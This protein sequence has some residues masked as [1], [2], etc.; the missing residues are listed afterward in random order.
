M[1]TSKSKAQQII[2]TLQ[3]GFSIGG[4]GIVK[5]KA[6]QVGRE[7]A[8]CSKHPNCKDCKRFGVKL[9]NAE[10]LKQHNNWNKHEEFVDGLIEMSFGSQHEEI[11]TPGVII[12]WHNIHIPGAL[13]LMDNVRARNWAIY[14]IRFDEGF[15]DQD[16]EEFDKLNNQEKVNYID[17]VLK[18]NKRKLNV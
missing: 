3:E 18:H 9:I 1:A 6:K 15:T 11:H 8:G 4:V 13:F 2:E 5:I 17:V 10:W 16:R 7:K 12:S 14:A